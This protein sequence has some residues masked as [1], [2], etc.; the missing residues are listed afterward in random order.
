MH[1]IL[2]SVETYRLAQNLEKRMF[3][4]FE[5]GVFQIVAFKI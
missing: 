3:R 4:I 2:F 1:K 5:T